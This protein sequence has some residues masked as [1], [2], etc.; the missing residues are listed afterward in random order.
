M[1]G[2]KKRGQRN[3]VPNTLLPDNEGK[4]EVGRVA[5]KMK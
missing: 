1:K 5:Q 4:K 3:L 2:G